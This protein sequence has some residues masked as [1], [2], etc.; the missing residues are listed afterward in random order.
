[1]KIACFKPRRSVYRAFAMLLLLTI[2]GCG[3][4]AGEPRIV[5]TIAPATPVPTEIAYPLTT[6]DLAAGAQIY[7]QHC[8]QCHGETGHGDGSLIGTGQGQIAKT[9]PDFADP[10]TAAS[11]TPLDWFNIITDGRI[12]NFM[13]P[14]R[15]TLTTQER[16]NVSMYIYTLHYGAEAVA[17]GKAL[18]DQNGAGV[19][20]LPDQSV[21]VSV[22][23]AQLLAKYAE[24]AA[25]I[26]SLD[27]SQQQDVAAY[28]RSLT[29]A[30]VDII[31]K[32]VAVPV[33]TEEPGAVST[34]AVT[35]TV[36][37]QVTNAT[38]GGTL[39][40]DLKATLHILDSQFN[41]TPHDT[42]VSAEGQFSFTAVPLQSDRS[43]IVTVVYQGRTFASDF[44]P[45]D[46]AAGKLDLPL[47]I[48]DI[49][50]DPSV[51]R[52]A[53]WV[54]Q[55]TAVENVLQIAQ[56]VS[57][58]N[59]SDKAYSTDLLPNDDR[60]ASVQVSLPAGAQILSIAPD[61]Q[62]Y[63]MAADSL[64]VIDT[65]PVM[66]D[67]QHIVQ[68]VYSV[69][70]TG[71]F[72]FDQLFD[73]AV[74]GPV[75]LLVTPDTISVTSDQLT[76]LGAQTIRDQ[77]YQGYGASLA[78]AAG[79]F[80]SYLVQGN[81]PTTST[82]TSIVSSGNLIPAI[83]IVV[84][85]LVL[86]VALVVYLRGRRLT[87]ASISPEDANLLIDGLIRQIAELDESFAAGTIDDD[88]YRKRREKLKTRLTELMDQQ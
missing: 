86:L 76:P 80:L 36:S 70:Y 5:S 18:V 62:R 42:A 84:G 9:P 19:A 60:Y 26:N 88:T 29:I 21:V 27:A 37:G 49:T 58:T 65:A 66:P 64:T 79:N 83:F 11:Q 7:A 85:V 12:D 48:Y 15:D 51:I 61:D 82:A 73:Y 50:N 44:L 20:N 2:A 22:T 6:P 77:T 53:G 56:V 16:W 8:T 31:G 13:P 41:D 25:F 34:A 52:I 33:A 23:D 4:L 67:E 40:T 43:Y 57:F 78:L 38:A 39:P 47:K 32:T 63:V 14:W 45:G 74:Q 75:R 59:T 55:I 17:Q 46:P 71:E 87:P 10:A 1:M 54:S 28:L 68:F 35:G 81:A 72:R 24:S 30:N 69:P 3:G